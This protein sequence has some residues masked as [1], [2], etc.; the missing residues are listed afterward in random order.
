MIPT[1]QTGVVFPPRDL[2]ALL[3]LGRAPFFL[4]WKLMVMLGGGTLISL[5]F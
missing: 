1:A 5:G 2:T 3:D 4:A